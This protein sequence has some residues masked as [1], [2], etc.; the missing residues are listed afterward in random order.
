MAN[1]QKELLFYRREDI[2]D[3]ELSR[4]FW[5]AFN[6]QFQEGAS[7]AYLASRLVSMAQVYG[8]R[9]NLWHGFIALYLARHEN[10]FSLACE[11]GTPD[12]GLRQIA[13]L[14]FASIKE[15]FDGGFPA[16]P[17]STDQNH[18]D[19]PMDLAGAT[20]RKA[21]QQSHQNHGEVPM[22]LAGI[23]CDYRPQADSRRM[24]VTREVA[25][26]LCAF[27]SDLA[28]AGDAATFGEVVVRYYQTHGVGDLGFYR[29]F[30]LIEEDGQ[31]SLDPIPN[32]DEIT[33]AD[34]V[35]YEPQK[36]KLIENTEIFLSGKPANNCLLYGDAGTGKSSS[37]K[38]TLNRYAPQGL[39][40]VEL[41]KHQYRLL[42]D[43]L[44]LLHGRNYRFIIYMDDLSFED[45]EAEYKYLKAVIEGGL[46][47]K[48]D[49][50]LI[51]ATSNRRHLIRERF[52]DKRSLDDELHGNDTVQEK[53]SLAARFGITIYFGSPDKGEFEEIVEALAARYHLQASR[54]ELLAAA[55]VWELSHGGRSGRAAMQLIMDLYGRG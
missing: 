27:A 26:G 16:S 44:Q 1:E 35:G 11:Y 6:G 10:A 17:G 46:G 37:I 15:L 40:V 34:I 33:F 14:D 13:E 54:E 38:A 7:P 30:R 41:F 22:D 4:L 48:P 45:D 19:V 2:R 31:V 42:P 43:L 23:I 28:A 49:N 18:G 21:D 8:L 20:L 50:A 3:W 55:N 29:A 24:S 12:A 9:G 52:S 32:P 5:L 36:K 53:L 25:D 39:R 51:Y 47:K